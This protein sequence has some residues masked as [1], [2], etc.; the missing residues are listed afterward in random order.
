MGKVVS[1]EQYNEVVKANDRLQKIMLAQTVL[2]LNKM[3]IPPTQE[4]VS[5][6]VA[7]TVE[8][9]KKTIKDWD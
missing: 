8:E 1:L 6:S 3:G 4:N 2:L 9:L 5:N 7:Q